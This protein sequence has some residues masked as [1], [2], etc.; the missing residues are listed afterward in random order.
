MMNLSFKLTYG[1]VFR[2]LAPPFV[3]LISQGE[4]P[5]SVREYV[6]TW[7]RQYVHKHFL[8]FVVPRLFEEKRRDIVFGFP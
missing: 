1:V 3:E 5:A 8:V 4:S 6:S 7:V 2:H